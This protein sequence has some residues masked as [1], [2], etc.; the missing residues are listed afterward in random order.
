MTNLGK[1]AVQMPMFI[2]GIRTI[3]TVYA[4]VCFRRYLLSFLVSSEKRERY[5]VSPNKINLWL[6]ARLLTADMII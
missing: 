6:C 3:V 2:L 5:L 4:H 1:V